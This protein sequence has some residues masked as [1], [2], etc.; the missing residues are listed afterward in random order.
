MEGPDAAADGEF[1]GVEVTGLK[2]GEGSRVRMRGGGC[3]AAVDKRV[4]RLDARR[5]VEDERVEGA[6]RVSRSRIGRS[7]RLF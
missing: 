2:I 1:G 4:G 7:C 3:A 6:R 5:G